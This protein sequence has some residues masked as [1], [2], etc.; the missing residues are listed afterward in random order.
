MFSVLKGNSDTLCQPQGL[1]T[2]DRLCI[3]T[4]QQHGVS[5]EFPAKGPDPAPQC[6]GL[7]LSLLGGL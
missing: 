7:F 6:S 2:G 5:S 4:D 1:V 3:T